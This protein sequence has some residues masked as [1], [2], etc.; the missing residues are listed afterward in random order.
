MSILEEIKY[1]LRALRI[2]FFWKGRGVGDEF[3]GEMLVDEDCPSYYRAK[4]VAE[5]LRLFERGKR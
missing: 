4:K 2:I 1:T 3:R 5:L